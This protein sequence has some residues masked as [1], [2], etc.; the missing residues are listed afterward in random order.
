V[1]RI[2]H[3]RGL[4]PYL[5]KIQFKRWAKLRARGNLHLTPLTRANA[6][7]RLNIW[8]GALATSLSATALVTPKML[9]KIIY[10]RSRAFEGAKLSPLLPDCFILECYNPGAYPVDMTFTARMVCQGD[11]P[12]FQTNISSAPGYTRAE[13]PLS[14]MQRCID[15]G[16]PFD[17]EIVPNDCEGKLLYFGLMD[18]VKKRNRNGQEPTAPGT[19]LLK[20][21]IWDLDNTLWDG[22]LIED[23][24]QKLRLRPGIIDVIAQLDQRGILNSIAS[25]NNHDE[26]TGVLRTFGIS[27]YFLYPQLNW[28][29]KSMSVAR[30]AQLLDIGLESVALVDDQEF[31]RDEVKAALPEVRVIDAMH[32]STIANLPECHVPVTQESRNR[33]RMYGE[34]ADRK[35]AQD[36]YQGD[37]ERFLRESCITVGITS[38]GPANLRRV[39]EL[40]QRTNQLNFSGNRY[41]EAQLAEIMTSPHLETYVIDC[42]DRYGSYGIVGFAVIE[43]QEPRL[44]DLMFS[45][46]VQGK[47]VEHAVL[48]FLLKRFVDGGKKDFYANYCRTPR[49]AV[50]G[51]VFDDIG[52]EALQESEGILSLV[53]KGEHALAED[54]VVTIRTVETE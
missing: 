29:P 18:F 45:C 38:L 10:L 39:Y 13:V 31:E 19:R 9:G 44:L 26:A 12:A 30:I 34:Q 22:V 6:W 37:Y 5:Q 51:R 16:Q 40:A 36:S 52:F 41:H 1:V 28:Q 21:V 42:C 32:G 50:A 14:D 7:E 2:D 48:L 47:R 11:T 46:R 23:G 3:K 8:A 15:L 53:F 49:N 25:K 20:C 4:S 24:P 35:V 17:I 27:D 33:R 43:P 54:D